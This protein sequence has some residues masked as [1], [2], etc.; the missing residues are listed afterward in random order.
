[1]NE[2]KDAYYTEE[3]QQLI[4][5]YLLNKLDN[6]SRA[7]FEEK[8]RNDLN[9]RNTVEEQ[10]LITQSV[11]EFNLRNTLDSFHTSIEKKS[12]KK[13]FYSWVAAAAFIAI[14]VGV[15]SWVLFFRK[16][17]TQQ[18]FSENFVADPGLPTTMGNTSDYL[19]YDGMVSYKRKNYTK[20]IEK[21][22]KIYH[23]KN[24]NDTLNYFLGVA[25]LAEGKSKMAQ[26]YFQ[27]AILNKNS[28]FYEEA[29]YYYA[30]SLIKEGSVAEA[31]KML[32]KS[33]YSKSVV[34]LN[35]L[36]KLN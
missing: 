7:A 6:T 16:N 35:Q 32:A 29:Q 13:I 28:V 34:L 15:T 33:S 12:N 24:K 3:M 26:I 1:M 21:W 5:D 36:E 9:L 23:E 30:L 27:R 31:K 11:E 19:F 22:K 10:K 14:L 18:I 25:N 4:D 20:A 17:T 8:M 2:N